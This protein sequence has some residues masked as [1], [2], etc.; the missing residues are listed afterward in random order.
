ME[1]EIEV[2]VD[3]EDEDKEL[4]AERL[5][6]M[7]PGFERF[8]RYNPVKAKIDDDIEKMLR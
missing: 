2:E 7:F 3:F 8:G 4:E 6:R 5:R 1:A